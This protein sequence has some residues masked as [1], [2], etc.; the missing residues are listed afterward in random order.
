MSKTLNKNLPLVSMFK[1]ND[2]IN[3]KN[4]EQKANQNISEKAS[5]KIIPNI[6]IFKTAS[7]MNRKV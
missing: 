4:T 7:I 6:K 2:I 5:V 3:G 1:T